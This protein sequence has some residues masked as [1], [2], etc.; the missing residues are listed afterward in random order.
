[1][2][3][4]YFGLHTSPFRINPDPDFYFES[5]GHGSALRYLR[6]GA[7]QGEGF[8]VLSGDIGAG[9]TT[10]LQA[11]LAELD[12]ARVEAAQLVS[13]QL[14]P[15]ELL[16]S[17]A[18][19]FGLVADA[20]SKARLLAALEARFAALAAQGR[21]ALLIVDEAQNLSIE[22]IEELRMLSNF[23]RGNRQLLQSFLVGQPELRARL[24]GPRMEQLRQRVIASCHLGALNAA[25]TR[26][27]VE[28]RLRHAGWSGR[29]EIDPRAFA[30]LHRFT[31]GVPRRINM[32]CGRAL[33]SLY[34]DEADHLDAA[35]VER[36][37]V[38]IAGELGAQPQDESPRL[39]TF[40]EP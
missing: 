18:I 1:M 37:A 3:E 7:Y 30:V 26:A 13:T 39:P 36:I 20:M 24:Q 11:L 8:L 14:A 40:Q 15:G 4:A 27:Y 12:P 23:Q 22:A 34:L 9:K 10:L 5:Q 21:R 25:E 28:H 29:P 6:F 19:A 17:V 31:G 2:Y 35:R 33:L 16:A 32:V 38:E